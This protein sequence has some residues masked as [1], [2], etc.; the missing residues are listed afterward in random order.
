MLLQLKSDMDIFVVVNAISSLFS[1][2]DI[3]CAA[4]RSADC[5]TGALFF[6]R[7]FP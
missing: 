2:F 4:N 1:I 6:Q 7:A 3:F 5:L